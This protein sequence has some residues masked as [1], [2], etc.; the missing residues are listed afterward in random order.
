MNNKFYWLKIL[1]GVISSCICIIFG[2]V[3]IVIGV[4][5]WMKV[6]YISWMSVT[7]IVIGF[8]IV[9]IGIVIV[10]RVEPKG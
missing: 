1:I 4:R 5:P 7:S 3:F 9:I 6:G 2:G 10:S 8:I